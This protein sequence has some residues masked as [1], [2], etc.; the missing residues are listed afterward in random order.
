MFSATATKGPR[1]LA[2][3]PVTFPDG[4][5]YFS[6][7]KRTVAPT[8]PVPD[9]RKMMRDPSVKMNR[10]PYLFVTLPSMGSSYEKS[11]TFST[12]KS[13]VLM[14]IGN[15]PVASNVSIVSRIASIM[16]LAPFAPTPS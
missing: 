5:S 12:E 11:S 1:A 9:K 8:E 4:S 15:F 3:I 13:P 14:V 6:R 2:G 16:S 10:M 7:Y